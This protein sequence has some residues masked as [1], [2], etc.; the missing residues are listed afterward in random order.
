[1]FGDSIDG[2]VERLGLS[3]YEPFVI[4]NQRRTPFRKEH[5]DRHVNVFFAPVSRAG[6]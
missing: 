1:V 6:A 4:E 3:G 5:H 2:I